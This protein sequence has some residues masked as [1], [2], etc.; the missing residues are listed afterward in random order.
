MRISMNLGIIIRKYLSNKSGN[1]AISAAFSFI[2]II[3]SVGAAI[4]YS[5]SA[6][7]H[8]N[9]ARATDAAL[10]AAVTEVMNDVDLDDAAAVNSK[11]NETFE[12]FFFANM[13]NAKPYEYN[14][15]EVNYDPNTRNA[16]VKVLVDYKAA[17]TTIMGIDGW[18]IDVEAAATMRMKAGGA[19]SMFLVLDRS[20]SMNWSNGDGGTK[21]NSLKS[22]VD[23]MITDLKAA[24]PDNKFIRMGAVAYSS[25][26]WEHQNVRWNLDKTNN[27]VQAMYANGGTDSS[28]AMSKAYSKLK[29]TA[30]QTQHMRKNGQEP[31]LIIVFM[32]DG[33]NN[34]SSDDTATINT[35]N[36]A[37]DYGMHIYTV[38][39]MAPSNGEALLSSCASSASHYFEPQN[40][41]EMIEAFK[42]IGDNVAES[43]V[44]S[45]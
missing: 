24:D 5:R 9:V 35:C 37:K 20:G 15:Y 43:L 10:L 45:Q 18:K 6:N 36:A 26:M 44:L 30:E 27:Y 19:V 14:G 1:T 28:D 31:K 25:Y 32:T 38:A 13:Y 3:F 11:L 17:A 34:Y 23:D 21:M 16:S 7:L 33:D 2:P 12:P 4:D 39:F 41:D 22:A 29:R 40:N 8:S 42:K